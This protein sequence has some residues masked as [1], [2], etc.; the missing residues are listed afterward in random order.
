VED[1]GQQRDVT[2]EYSGGPRH[3]RLDRL[4]G[5]VDGLADIL[6]TR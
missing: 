1:A 4:D 5:S 3:P 2:I 6:R